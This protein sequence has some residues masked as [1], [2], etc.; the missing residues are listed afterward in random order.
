MSHYKSPSG[1]LFYENDGLL[2]FFPDSLYKNQRPPPVVITQIKVNNQALSLGEESPLKITSSEVREIILSHKQNYLSFE[3]AALNYIET[4]A[5]RYKYKLEGREEDWID[6]GTNRV[7][8]YQVLSPGT[9]N[10]RE[11]ASN[12]DAV[13]NKQGAELKIIIRPPWWKSLPAIISY[14]II[15]LLA[16]Y[17]I[18]KVREQKISPG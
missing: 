12:N 5:N 16:I 7:A 2:S 14:I 8:S 17:I 13:W 11:S 10:F 9:Y 6:A 3:F 1:E 4:K 18:V 15:L